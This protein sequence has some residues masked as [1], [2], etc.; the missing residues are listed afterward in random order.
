MSL[1]K[2]LW[3]E[4]WEWVW[5]FIKPAS[6]V[7]PDDG[8][9]EH[10][11]DRPVYKMY[12]TKLKVWMKDSGDYNYKVNSYSSEKHGTNEPTISKFLS[13]LRGAN[14]PTFT[15]TTDN[16]VVLVIRSQVRHVEI[17]TREYETLEP[18]TPV[19]EPS[20]PEP[21][22]QNPVEPKDPKPQEANTDAH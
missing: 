6:R 11:D 17:I 2:Q 8:F 15:I 18:P 1:I 22:D 4:F 9:E 21:I 5:D 20:K 12:E 16:H 7:K 19:E 13:W 10:T 14:T 3:N